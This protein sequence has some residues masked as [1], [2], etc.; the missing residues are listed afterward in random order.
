MTTNLEKKQMIVDKVSTMAKHASLALAADY[1]SMTANQMNQLR[2]QAR[3]DGVSVCIVKN[4]LARKALSDT[5]YECM[6]DELK[7]PLALFFSNEEPAAAARVIHTFA[8][9]NEGIEAKVI[10]FNGELRDLSEIGRLASLP[11]RE[12]ALAILLAV[13][14]EPIAQLARILAAPT[15]KLARTID[16][17]RMQK[18]DHEKS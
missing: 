1:Q 16:A 7:G 2:K 13:M 4:T 9:A 17:V 11:N 12:Q 5:P 14:K 3:E 8:K 10:S 18:R 15:A 6:T